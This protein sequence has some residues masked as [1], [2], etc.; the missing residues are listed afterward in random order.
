MAQELI[1][2]YTRNQPIWYWQTRESDPVPAI[3]IKQSKRGGVIV[4]IANS[5]Q[6]PTNYAMIAP[7]EQEAGEYGSHRNATGQC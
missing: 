7:R 4:E 1:T 5:A 6:K 2:T 3:F